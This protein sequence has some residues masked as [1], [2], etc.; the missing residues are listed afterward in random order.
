MAAQDQAIG[1]DCCKDKILKEEI[2]SKCW[3]CKAYE[4]TIHHLT[5]GCRILVK[6]EYLKSHGSVCAHFHYSI[7]KTF[8]RFIKKETFVH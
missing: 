7:C 3:L 2:D 4:E 1:T 8:D 6:N 5:L